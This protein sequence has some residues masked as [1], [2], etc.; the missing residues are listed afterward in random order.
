[1]ALQGKLQVGDNV[2]ESAYIK[3]VKIRLANTDYEV[4]EN[5]DDPDNPE[6]A[7]RLKWI[8]RIEGFAT[9]IIWGDRLSRENR[10]ASLDHFSFEFEFN[11]GDDPFVQA[12]TALKTANEFKDM[13]DV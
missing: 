1:M 9:A 4:F 2:F 13:E 6:I 7:Q 10:A 12:Y 3:I 8:T 11:N 5:V